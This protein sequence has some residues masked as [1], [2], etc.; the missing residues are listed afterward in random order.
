MHFFVMR[1]SYSPPCGK[2]KHLNL[3]NIIN[4][5]PLYSSPLCKRSTLLI[6]HNFLNH[7][8]LYFS[9]PYLKGSTLLILPTPYLQHSRIIKNAIGW[10]SSSGR[11]FKNSSLSDEFLLVPLPARPSG[12]VPTMHFLMMR[13]SSTIPCGKYTIPT[14]FSHRAPTSSPPLSAPNPYSPHTHPTPNNSSAYSSYST[15]Y[16]RHP[17]AAR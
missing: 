2:N 16:P 15:P 11:Y 10:A 9:S 7:K 1:L 4:H 12:S 8:P 13:L 6:L 5:K 3:R 14:S 17:S